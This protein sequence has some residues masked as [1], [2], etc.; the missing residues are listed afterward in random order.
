M[1]VKIVTDRPTT[2]IGRTKASQLIMAALLAL[3][4]G[5]T[6]AVSAAQDGDVMR[7]E[8]AALPAG[9]LPRMDGL[10]LDDPAWTDVEA[11]A[12][13]WQNT[14]DEGQP[15]TE[16]TEIRI[17][18][19][20]DTLYFGVVCFDRNPGSIIVSD[21]RRDAP[22]NETDAFQIILDT[23]RD[24]QNGFVFGTNPAG[25]E[26]DGQV[27]N[28]GQGVLNASPQRGGSAGGFNIN[29]D[30]SWVVRTQI[31]EIGWS[32]EFAI[33]FRT[34]RFANG[35]S[36]VWG[37]NFQRNIRRR[38]E[39]A[40][41]APL[42]LQFNLHRL[43]LAGSL[44]GL[45]IPSQRNLKVMPYALGETS[46][47]VDISDASQ[48]VGV[49]LKYSLTPS[50]TLDLSYNT[51][52]AQVEV[53]DQQ[54]NLDRFQLF[55]PEKRPFFLENAGLFSVGSPQEVEMFFSR[56][57]GIGPEGSLVPIT[58]GGRLT[59]KIGG[60]DVG[61]LNMSTEAVAAT[62]DL[63]AVPT[64]NFTVARVNRELP[65]RSALGAML[66]NRQGLGN[67]APKDDVNRTL[68]VDGRL[69]IGRYGQI[70]GFAAQTS[71]PGLEGDDVAFKLGANY[72]SEAWQLVANYT[73][74]ARNFNPE[75]GFLRRDNFSKADFLIW[76]RIRPKNFF[77]LHEI[78]PHT[79][80]R[81]FWNDS[82]GFHETGFL[83]IDS[84]W[85]W[86][87]GN[88][89]HTGINFTREGVAESDT[90]P[91]YPGIVVPP[92]T[93]DHV[94]TQ[95]V[96]FTNRGHWW[97]L[98]LRSVIGGYFGGTR[99]NLEPTV[100]IRTGEKFNL[101]VSW[102][103][104]TIDL[105]VGDFITNLARTKLSYAF[106]PRLFLLGLL[107]YNDRDELW[108]ANVQLRWLQDANTGLFMVYNQGGE[109]AGPGGAIKSTR[110]RSLIIKYTHLFD[111]FK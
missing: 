37:L 43:S 12:E 22:L 83:H 69:G 40:F 5:P 20:P 11:V 60:T 16:R 62:G 80:Y 102:S 21:S 41:W 46:R 58:G 7:P 96:A 38:N 68:A 93:Y 81:G 1:S 27:T 88:E 67:L 90:F 98:G 107:Q 47:R 99:I 28:E 3:G 110:D 14:P 8:A 56:R 74:V 101:S 91:I 44:V 10:V 2:C 105:P 64:N 54:I 48:A 70:I 49:D 73:E 61:M 13:L 57:I 78:R 89:V 52:F 55:F 35:G 85:E 59:G 34:L 53:D 51:D 33:P 30:G 87:N 106:T 104:N 36:Q 9:I 45:D 72:N 4:V 71:T 111:V 75:V 108:S 84:H 97:S 6:A 24:G 15:A 42:P 25:I 94:E 65:N 100:D 19:S 23:Y 79:S 31:S 50:L 95:L 32:A 18:Y 86:E 39:N 92:G 17:L 103:R 63:E 77:G 109:V 76:R 29:W 82:T 66:V 26:Y